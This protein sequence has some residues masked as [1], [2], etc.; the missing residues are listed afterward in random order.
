MSVP[1]DEQQPR[2]AQEE[3]FIKQ[4]QLTIIESLVPGITLISSLI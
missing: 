4:W 1:R 3:M 2:G